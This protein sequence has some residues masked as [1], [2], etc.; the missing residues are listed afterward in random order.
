MAPSR[1]HSLGL[2]H[3][4]DPMT[5]VLGVTGHRPQKLHG[6]IMD[7]YQITKGYLRDIN[8][9]MVNIGMAIGFDTIVAKACINLG[10]DYTAYIPFV[11][12]E[13]KWTD[14]QK[15]TYLHICRFA[16]KT[17]IIS[18]GSYSA[19]KMMIRNLAIVDNSTEIL[20]CWDGDKV[21]G[22]WN[23]IQAAQE[24]NLPVTNLWDDY[25]TYSRRPGVFRDHQR[26]S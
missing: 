13:E 19:K 8:P 3:G 21:G 16:A 25:I 7:L 2:S 23:A 26:K 11:G 4:D 9:D 17:K 1:S 6:S 18:P 12:Q 24:V 15:E 10:L 14:R 22:T 20:A 5:K